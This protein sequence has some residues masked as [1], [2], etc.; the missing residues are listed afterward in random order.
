M[1]KAYVE[2]Y[3]CSMNQGYGAYLK[4]F[5]KNNSVQLSTKEKADYIL[6]NTCGVK[7]ATKKHMVKRAK[8]LFNITKSN[9][10]RLIVT[11]CLPKIESK[12]IDDIS[13]KIIQ[14]DPELENIAEYFE[15]PLEENIPEIE[16]IRVNPNIT[17]LPIC[18]GCTSKCA[19]CAT[20]IARGNI[21]SYP[22]GRLKSKLIDSL[23][24]TKE[25]WLTG[26][27]TGPYGIDIGTNLP[28]LLRE[29][30]TIDG[31]FRLRLGMM[32][33]QYALRFIDEILPLFRDERMYRFLHLPIQ[34]GSDRILKR[35]RRNYTAKLFISLIENI[36]E[37]Y[38][39]MTISTDIIAGFPGET[40]A[41]FQKTIDVLKL[42]QPDIVN[43]SSFSRSPNTEAF[44][45]PGQIMPI[46][47]KQ[48]TRA[49]TLLCREISK[50][51]NQNMLGYNG[52]ALFTEKGK[53]GNFVGRMQNYKPVVVEENRLGSFAEVRIITCHPTYLNGALL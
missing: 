39:D 44:D 20:K 43:I 12:L 24:Q 50:N 5:L 33:P 23:K 8:E 14:L 48:R 6:L 17:I 26:Q 19:F 16:E 49:L 51:R 22:V 27:D 45:M 35:M 42:T 32:N 29:L 28:S 25:F 21:K 41:D 9:N 11:G 30:L 31:E 1:M 47:K 18:T 34:S 46:I 37:H 36:R 4:G 10:S 15:F 52:K 3:G 7:G 53:K 13:P 2:S 40:D 38:P